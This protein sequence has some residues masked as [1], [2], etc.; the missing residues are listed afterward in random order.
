[1]FFFSNEII[2]SIEL[3][4]QV[5]CAQQVSMPRIYTYVCSCGPLYVILYALLPFGIEPHTRLKAEIFFNSY[6]F[7]H[8]CLVWNRVIAK[9]HYLNPHYSSTWCIFQFA[10]DCVGLESVLYL[11]TTVHTHEAIRSFKYKAQTEST[12]CQIYGPCWLDDISKSK[13]I[14]L[15]NSCFSPLKFL[16]ILHTSLEVSF[17]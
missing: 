8:M 15:F 1:M 5:Y 6:R 9:S 11:L 4:E 10:D 3:L 12:P 7:A 16:R 13:T 17:V 2:N 14:S